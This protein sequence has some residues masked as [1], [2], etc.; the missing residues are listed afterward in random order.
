MC[1]PFYRVNYARM[2]PEHRIFYSVSEHFE[3]NVTRQSICRVRNNIHLCTKYIY[4]PR[5]DAETS[6][7][8]RLNL[9]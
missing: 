4:P 3:L 9:L 2:E 6:N 7:L 8:I 5:I 1:V